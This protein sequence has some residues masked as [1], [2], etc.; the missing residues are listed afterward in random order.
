MSIDP[1][2]K[3]VAAIEWSHAKKKA[4]AQDLLNK[5]RFNHKPEALL[6]FEEVRSRFKLENPHCLGVMDIPLDQIV[7]SMG[8]Y[9]DFTRTF[10]PR[11]EGMRQRWETV[12]AV[13]TSRGAPP[14]HVYK[15]GDAY[16]VADGNHRVSV[17]RSRD[18]QT[19]EAEVWEYD[20]D[21]EIDEDTTIDEVLLQAERREFLERTQLDDL[22]PDHAITFSVAG[23]YVELE[24]QIALYREVLE[25]IDQ[26]EITWEYA[27]TAWY[28]LVY[29]P[30]VMIIR[31]EG[32]L[33]QFPD[34]TEADI[35]AWFSIHR[36]QV[37]ARYG[38]KVSVRDVARQLRGPLGWFRRL[39]ASAEVGKVK[40]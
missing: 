4:A 37:S 26:E 21:I 23:R 14:I 16:F 28:D 18:A 35:F 7:G 24:Y 29:E 30:T 34:R 6:P 31:R 19:I 25:K 20:T 1:Y 11:S 3:R 36:Q 12:S 10:L 22:R 13:M 2:Y 17:A 39:F 5:I 38:L 32:L 33:A 27:V 8:R 15:V 40:E 9:R